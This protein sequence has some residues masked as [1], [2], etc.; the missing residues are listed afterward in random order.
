[1]AVNA[2]NMR[3]IIL[4]E[5]SFVESVVGRL[6]IL[7]LFTSLVGSVLTLLFLVNHLWMPVLLK[8]TVLA[9][10]GVAA[11]FCS[12]RLLIGRNFLLRFGAAIFALF[13][14]LGL[15]NVLSLGFIGLNLLRAYPNNPQWDGALQL[16]FTSMLAA[17]TIRAWR[18]TV[19]EVVV[20]PRYT[21][22]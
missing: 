2:I 17:L 11:G 1:M 19:R 13:I 18:I 6:L 10:I 14:T 12:R 8:F 15:L 20:E 16:F 9:A 7:V 21:P 5:G 4:G 22:P 3:R